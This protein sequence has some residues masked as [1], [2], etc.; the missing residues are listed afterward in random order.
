MDKLV[1]TAINHSYSLSLS[2]SLKC[3][4][5]HTLSFKMR[6]THQDTI[7]TLCPSPLSP[8]NNTDKKEVS[9]VLVHWPLTWYDTQEESKPEWTHTAV[10]RTPGQQPH[11]ISK[12]DTWKLNHRHQLKSQ[13]TTAVTREPGGLTATAQEHM[14]INAICDTHY[15]WH[16][17]THIICDTLWH[18]LSVT[19]IICDT[20][21]LYAADI[22][23]HLGS[24]SS[25]GIQDW[26]WEINAQTVKSVKPLFYWSAV[27]L[28]RFPPFYPS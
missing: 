1:Y 2:L 16:T 8:P 7:K 22:H 20:H 26:G 9:L 4:H 18:T 17:V 11:L 12:A 21:Y 15:L 13:P 28:L 6:K 3:A 27:C 23:P 10:S 14:V 19:H 5:T 25:C 24:D